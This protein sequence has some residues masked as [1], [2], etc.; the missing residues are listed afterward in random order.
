MLI[1]KVESTTLC[2]KSEVYILGIPGDKDQK[3]LYPLEANL[4]LDVFAVPE[5]IRKHSSLLLP[6]HAKPYLL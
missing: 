2:C 6:P 3:I 4:Q 5:E 1:F